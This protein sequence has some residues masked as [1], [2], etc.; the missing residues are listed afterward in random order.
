MRALASWC[1]ALAGL[2]AEDLGVQLKMEPAFS[3]AGIFE[4]LQRQEAD[5]AAAGLAVRDI[6]TV[7]SSLEEVFL[8]LV[9]E[10][11]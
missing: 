8:R 7:Q 4:Q 3:L 10:N 5:F 2:L 6:S 1:G 9:E 11:A